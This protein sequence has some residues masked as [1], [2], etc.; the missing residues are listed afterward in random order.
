M[1]TQQKGLTVSLS[2]ADTIQ[3]NN[4]VIST[5]ANQDPGHLTF[6]NEIVSVEQGKNGNTIYAQN[7]MGYIADLAIRVLLAGIDDQYL[8]SLLQQQTTAF[9][10]F[11]LMTALFNKRVGDGQGNILTVVYQLSGGVVSKGIEQFTSAR[12]DVN[13]SVAVWPIRFGNWTRLIQ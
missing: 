6:P 3:V 11:S 4:Q 8:N 2:G 10:D 7:N 1:P 13:Q 9:S 12:G 5:L